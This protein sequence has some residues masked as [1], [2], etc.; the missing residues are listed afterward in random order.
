MRAGVE[1]GSPRIL[2]S[3]KKDITVEHILKSAEIARDRG[4]HV[5]YSFVIGWPGE[6]DQDRQQTIDLCFRL[7]DINPNVTMYPLWNYIPYPGTPHFTE[8]IACG[9]KQPEKLEDWSDYSWAKANSPWIDSRAKFE[10]I[11]TL[12]KFAFFNRDSADILKSLLSTEL[13]WRTKVRR[14][15]GMA[16]RPWAR[17]RLKNSSRS[18]PAP[19]EY[20]I[21]EAL[22]AGRA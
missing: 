20:R 15:G 14:V 18:M 8:A 19:Y 10:N 17:Y 13:R 5:R 3:I 12:S 4:F 22:L 7:F 6:T 11:H 16:V 21:I 2:K 1:S 9:F